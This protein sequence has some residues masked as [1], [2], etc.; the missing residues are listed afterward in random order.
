MNTIQ[1]TT[2]LEKT[3]VYIDGFNL[4]YGA[5]H[6]NGSGY[7]WLNLQS[8]LSKILK[9]NDIKK[10]KYYTARVS[11]KYDA[12]KPIKQESYFRALKTLDCVEIIE[13]KFLFNNKRIRISDDVSLMVKVPEEKGT[14]VNL[15]VQ[16]VHDA[17]A[18]KFNTA[19]VVSNDSDLAESIRIVANELHLNIGIVSPFQTFN[20]QI[21]QYASFKLPARDGAIMSSQFPSVLNDGIG[22]FAKPS[23]W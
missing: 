11:G 12:G 17:H 2:Q 7:K 22:K 19:V 9:R 20:K 15:A 23:G 4:Y 8:W 18:G 1:R 6:G 16:L 13:G 3:Y 14:D 21:T 5:L 10:I